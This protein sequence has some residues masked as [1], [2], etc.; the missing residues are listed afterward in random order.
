MTRLSPAFKIILYVTA[1]NSLYMITV[2]R[3]LSIT[4]Y[5]ASSANGMITAW[6]GP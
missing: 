1:I 5:T 3:T 4:F 2:T 6:E